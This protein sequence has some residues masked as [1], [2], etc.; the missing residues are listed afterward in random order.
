MNTNYIFILN[1]V[2]A[3]LFLLFAYYLPNNDVIAVIA[4]IIVLI[5][6][7]GWYANQNVDHFYASL[8][9]YDSL[10]N[11]NKSNVNQVGIFYDHIDPINIKIAVG[12]TVTFTNKTNQSVQIVFE[13]LD[14]TYLG[15][16]APADLTF[17]YSGIFHYKVIVNGWGRIYCGNVLVGVSDDTVV[18]VCPYKDHDHPWL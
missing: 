10:R 15:R 14:T 8:G 6:L 12:D 9:Y 7:Y 13:A 5:N 1:I 4:I 17:N 16:F 11:C 3:I 2:I 18:T